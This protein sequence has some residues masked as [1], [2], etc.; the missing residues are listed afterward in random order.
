MSERITSLCSQALAGHY[1]RTQMALVDAIRELDARTD[2]IEAENV[3]LRE[4]VKSL[5]AVIAGDDVDDDDS[6][7]PKEDPESET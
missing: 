4:R 1:G 2:T 3:T 6:G 7:I 5:E